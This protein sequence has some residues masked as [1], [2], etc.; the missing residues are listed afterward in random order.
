M[1][2][3]TEDKITSAIFKLKDNCN[4]QTPLIKQRWRDNYDMFVSG[5]Q[6]TDKEDWQTNFSVNRIGSSTRTAQGRLLNTLIQQPDWYGLEPR[7][8]LNKRAELLAPAVQ[9][10]LNYYL[11]AGQFKRHA[12][13][14]FLN[15]LLNSGSIHVGWKKI[16]VQNP[17]HILAKTEEARQAE[18]ARLAKNVTNP[19]TEVPDALSGEK[20]E[21]SLLEALGEF[22]A[23][24]QG[25]TVSKP[26][27][28]PYVQIGALDFID[29][30]PERQYWNPTVTYMEDSQWRAFD[31]DVDL[32]ELNHQAKLGVF[33]KSAIKRITAPSVDNSQLTIQKLRY[34]NITPAP[35]VKT[36]VVKITVYEGPLIIDNEIVK[37]RY[38][39]VIA[40]DKVILK[41]GDYPYWEPPGHKTAF[42][43]AAVRQV[44]FRATGAGL[45]DNAVG[46][47][48]LYD[49]NW[50][51]VCDTFRQ[52]IAGINVVNF[53]NLV[54][55]GQL[56][57]G[58]YPGMTLEVRG[59][60]D[61]SFKR[62]DLTSNTENQN[63]PVQSM[64]E[65]AI[66]SI[67]GVNELQTGGGNQFSRTPATETNARLEAGNNNV[68]TIALDLEQTFLLPI[69]QKCLARV[70]QFGITEVV[71]NPELQSL[72]TDE[73]QYEINELNAKSR[74][75]ILNQWYKFKINGF[76][77]VQ[78]KQA[79]MRS[80]NELLQIV[81]SGGP[82]SQL[83]NLPEFMKIYF[84][85]MDIKDTQ[86]LLIQDSPLAQLTQ[87]T[88]VLMSGHMVVPSQNDD[89][90]F[91][92]KNQG[93]IAQTPYAT[94]ELQQHLQYHQ[95]MLMQMQAAQGQQAEGQSESVV[96]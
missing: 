18:Q 72:L 3:E 19:E 46:L 59:E 88:A 75:E 33:P 65:Q 68:N 77:N 14:F 7:S 44:P 24:A 70:L 58:I 41:D 39:C 90:E 40:N 25:E 53:T 13:T 56:D 35:G 69:L 57:E 31:Y 51:L 74:L 23:E 66:D 62:I 52:G 79:R 87:E 71:S 28:K 8:K 63:H 93:P 30:N 50:Q 17:E 94:P 43:T 21:S 73:E 36:D 64:L 83:V 95:Q 16:L 67:T 5:T 80:N 54:D 37:E 89:H 27:L 20:M 9:K 61:K 12:G 45:G 2:Q 78:D 92:I 48:K 26:K 10:I 1:R 84:R 91:H 76:S 29:I 86:A 6:N 42:I 47:Q 49:S 85:D 15:A 22:V 96:Q 32:F 82:L 38:F 34:G 4:K 55:K 11:E 60:P 81:N